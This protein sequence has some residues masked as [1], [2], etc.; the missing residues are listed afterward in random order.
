MTVPIFRTIEPEMLNYDMYLTEK[1]NVAIPISCANQTYLDS[2]EEALNRR[3]GD[4]FNKSYSLDAE[5]K[6]FDKNILFPI[7]K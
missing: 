1:N 4:K 7:K 6:D 2:L 3:Y 5:A